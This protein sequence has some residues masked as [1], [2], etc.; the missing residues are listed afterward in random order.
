MA[1]ERERTWTIK[2]LVCHAKAFQF[3]SVSAGED[4]KQESGMVKS[5]IV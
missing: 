2:S 5:C 1:E 4:F 3:D